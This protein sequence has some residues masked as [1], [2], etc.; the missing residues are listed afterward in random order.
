[1]VQRNGIP[2]MSSH[3]V[4]SCVSFSDGRKARVNTE[5]EKKLKKQRSANVRHCSAETL[6]FESGIPRPLQFI[7]IGRRRRNQRAGNQIRLLVALW[8]SFR[9]SERI[10]LDGSKRA[11][12]HVVGGRSSWIVSGFATGPRK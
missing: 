5:G 1:M 12:E 8:Q 3:V 6:Q 11:C 9:S 4:A 7:S 2:F 10:I